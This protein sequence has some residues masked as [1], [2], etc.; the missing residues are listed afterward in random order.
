MLSNNSLN[1]AHKLAHVLRQDKIKLI[2]RQGSVI[3]FLVATFGDEF[4]NQQLIGADAEAM[5]EHII[6]SANATGKPVDGGP[7][8]HDEKMD[9]A[10]KLIVRGVTADL[11]TAKN[12]AKPLIKELAEAVEKEWAAKTGDIIHG[13]HINSSDIDKIFN[14]TKIENLFDRYSRGTLEE[15]QLP[16]VFPELEYSEIARRVKTGDEELNKAIDDMLINTTPDGLVNLYNSYFV[17]RFADKSFDPKSRLYGDERFS[18]EAMLI[19]YFLSLGLEAD[20]PDGVDA[21]ASALRVSMGM[22]RGAI[23][24]MIKRR[25]IRREESIKN[26]MLVVDYSRYVDGMSDCPITVNKVVYENFLE[27]GGTPEAIFGAVIANATLTY[28]SILENR[29]GHE[30]FWNNKLELY[31]STNIQNKLTVVIEA[32][33]SSVNKLIASIPVSEATGSN[34]ERRE[35][36]REVLSHTYAKDLD[37]LPGLVRKV[38]CRVFYTQRPVMEYIIS[39]IDKFEALE[40]ETTAQ[41]AGHVTLKLVSEWVAKNIQSVIGT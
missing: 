33:R 12:E 3:D 37:D 35:R 10:K 16:A 25:L 28:D 22:F 2:P 18:L 23:G 34:A 11:Q 41:I 6:N 20:L 26:K 1:E 13:Y 4:K 14:S 27:A 38:I 30:T 17:R 36:L 29:L 15:V 39:S 19:V 9:W 32:I 24:T 40:G 21:S 8:I 7:S 5:N 31:R